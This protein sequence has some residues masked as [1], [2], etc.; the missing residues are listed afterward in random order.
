MVKDGMRDY[1]GASIAFRQSMRIHEK[2]GNHEGVAS[3]LTSLGLIEARQ[4][5]HQA[6]ITM[7]LR[8]IRIMR[9][10]FLYLQAAETYALS[11]PSWLAL[12]NP[13]RAR[14]FAERAVTLAR[15]AGSRRKEAVAIRSLAMCDAFDH[16]W[17]DADRNFQKAIRLFAL[18]KAD[19]EI[20]RTLLE[21][22]RTFYKRYMECFYRESL[23][24]SLRCLQQAH[25]IYKI[26]GYR[27]RAALTKLEIE[28][29][30]MV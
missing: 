1:H 5:R 17:T 6:A 18:E 13:D 15:R 24:K 23:K 30:L 19:V 28:R 2:M 27:N 12:D 10:F 29:V 16:E 22:G 7:F 3:S 14:S 9:R 26:R 25:T 8:A 20:A 4:D 21:V 11:V